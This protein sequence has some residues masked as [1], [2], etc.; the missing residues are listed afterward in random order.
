MDDTFEITCP[1]C[2]EALEIY[3]EPDVHG[4]YIQD[5][6]VCCQPMQITVVD[7]EESRYVSVEPADE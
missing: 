6:E 2:G 1:S 5:C 3:V 7:D 4:T